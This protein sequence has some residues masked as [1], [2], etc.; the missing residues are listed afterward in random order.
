VTCFPL[1]PV[2]PLCAPSPGATR[3]DLPPSFR[4]PPPWERATHRATHRSTRA[5]VKV[6]Y[7]PKW[8]KDERAKGVDVPGV[9]G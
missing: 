5:Q 2:Y 9:K 1:L 6:D 8:L 3:A 7:S 4:R